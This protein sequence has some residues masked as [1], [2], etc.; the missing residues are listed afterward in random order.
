MERL[1]KRSDETIHEN[2]VCCVH[3]MS[4]ECCKRHGDCAAGCPWEEAAWSRLAA[5]EDAGLTPEEFHTYW[6]FLQDLIG[7]QKA[8]EALDRFRELVKDDRDGRVIVLPCK[9]G[10]L[11]RD[12]DTG[13]AVKI[14]DVQYG[15]KWKEDVRVTYDYSDGSH[16]GALWES[17]RGHFIRIDTEK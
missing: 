15:M 4:E 8:S 3:F 7:D 5:Y 13:R 9:V 6:V 1:T 12:Q 11:W 14:T 2:G 10:E 16:G 17:F